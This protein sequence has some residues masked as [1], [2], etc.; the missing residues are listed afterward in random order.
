MKNWER[1]ELAVRNFVAALDPN[2]TV[3]YNVKLP[4]LDTGKPR[5]RDVWVETTVCNIFPVRVLVSCK[6]WSRKINQ[7]DIDAFVGELRSSG[8]HKGVLY[9]F[10]GYTEPAIEKA[11][12]LGISCCKLYNDETPDLPKYL[13]ISFYCCRSSYRIKVNSEAKA[14]WGNVTFNEVFSTIEPDQNGSC[15]TLLDRLDSAF[16]KEEDSTVRLA[17]ENHIFP[18]SWEV[19]IKIT[20]PNFSPLIIYLEG[21]WRI[22]RAKIEG[23]LLCGTYSFTENQFLGSLS[24]PWID[25]QGSEPGPYWDFI[26]DPPD[27]VEPGVGIIILRS[28]SY[29]EALKEHY[30]NLKINELSRNKTNQE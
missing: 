28:G 13:I 17:S 22:F 24:S 5:Q 2:A 30:G 4:D 16:L 14:D 23:H 27:L 6:K 7:Q 21:K 18:K 12:K 15:K 11:R 20:K 3:K 29:M 9:T 19:G 26:S 25:T 8:A 10:R 1:F